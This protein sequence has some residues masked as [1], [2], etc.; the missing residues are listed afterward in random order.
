[1]GIFSDPLLANDGTVDR[2][3]SFRSQLSDKKTV[4]GEWIEPLAP[5]ADDSRILIKHDTS[6]PTVRRRLMQVVSSALL[7]DGVTRKPI[8]IN[9]TVTYH[10][11]H[12]EA[13][14]T[15]RMKILLA[16]AGKATFLANF[17]RG[18]I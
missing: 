5:L 7:L 1:M 10:P 2:S 6:S 4:V 17:L 15:K 3:F 8:V 18:L 12:S 9:L 11:S 13:E 16:A 14:I